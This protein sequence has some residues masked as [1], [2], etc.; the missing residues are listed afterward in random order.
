M[1]GYHEER[2]P[3]DFEPPM[4][5]VHKSL[6]R[7]PAEPLWVTSEKWGLPKGALICLSYGTG[8]ILE[9]LPDHVGVTM[10]GGVVTVPIAPMPTGIMRGRFHPGDGQL[11]AAGLFGWA[12]D[13][14]KAGGFYRVRYAGKPVHLPIALHAARQGMLITFSH[15]LDPE[16]AAD[17]ENYAVSRWTYNR[18]ANYGSEDYKLSQKGQRGRDSVQVTGV[19]LSPDATSVLLEIPDMQPCMQMEI[20]YNLRA[21]DG[22]KL[23]Q[24]IENTIHTVGPDYAFPLIR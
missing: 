20:K 17:A 7:S 9:V 21:A 5:W 12:S 15:P 3:D 22:S 11:Y 2:S 4:V 8:K 18:T 19:K 14:T 13:K 23:S 16:A 10:Q 24:L 1:M 6:D